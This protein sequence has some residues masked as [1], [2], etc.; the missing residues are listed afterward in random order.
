MISIQQVKKE[1]RCGYA[2]QVCGPWRMEVKMDLGEPK[3]DGGKKSV[4]EMLHHLNLFLNRLFYH[5]TKRIFLKN[6]QCFEKK[7][8]SGTSCAKRMEINS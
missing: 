1:L 7:P 4:K 8:S 5:F 6:C 2:M 3:K